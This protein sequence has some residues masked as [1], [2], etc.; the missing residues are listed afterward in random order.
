MTVVAVLGMQAFSL[1]G[2]WHCAA[3]DGSQG[4]TAV[5]TARD[6][7]LDFVYG[8]MGAAGIHYVLHGEFS[9]DAASQTWTLRERQTPDL[10]QFL[11]HAAP[12]TSQQWTFAG[13]V[14]PPD[15]GDSI[16]DNMEPARISFTAFGKDS[17]EM[18]R[19]QQ[20][21][22]Q[23]VTHDPW[24]SNIMDETCVRSAPSER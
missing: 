5:F 24:T 12:W 22:G 13:A 21:G 11:G 18:V 3:N 1:A 23:W 19:T 15:P 4:G 10:S 9:Y 17:F 6:S 7:S 16:F 2:S 20:V 14:Y 8:F